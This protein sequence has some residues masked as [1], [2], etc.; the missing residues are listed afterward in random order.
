MSKEKI[1]GMQEFGKLLAAKIDA[2]KKTL[3]ELK[4]Q[5]A[6]SDRNGWRLKH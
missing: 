2:R 5:R 3:V 6:E 4:K 1:P